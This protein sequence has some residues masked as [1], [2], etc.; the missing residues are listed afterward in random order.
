MC[1]DEGDRLSVRGQGGASKTTVAFADW[2]AGAA[3]RPTPLTPFPRLSACPAL[4][5]SP[6][7]SR[8]PG[9]AAV[10]VVGRRF[11]GLHPPAPPHRFCS[12]THLAHV[13]PLRRGLHL[14]QSQPGR[15]VHVTRMAWQQH[16]RGSRQRK[17]KRMGARKKCVSVD[18]LFLSLSSPAHLSA[19]TPPTRHTHTHTPNMRLHAPVRLPRGAVALPPR[20]SASPAPRRRAPPSRR[21]P[22]TPAATTKEVTPKKDAQP[23]ASALEVDSVLQQELAEN[24]ELE[25]R[26]K[27]E[28]RPP[29]PSPPPASALPRCK[30]ATRLR[31][32][33][34]EGGSSSGCHARGAGARRPQFC[35]PP[36]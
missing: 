29:H 14:R 17:K 28:A 13:Q 25:G 34:G 35:F 5:Q 31:G 22:A 32:V 11:L 20:A 19:H 30:Q 36:L 8:R 23:A 27:A 2:E 26:H 3:R 16:T 4:H 6:A 24:G 7:A 10:S 12:P 1:V 21:S 18:L 9:S 15:R 33:W